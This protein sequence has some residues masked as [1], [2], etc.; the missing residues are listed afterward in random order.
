M[1]A[2][3]RLAPRDATPTAASTGLV[4]RGR[5]SYRTAMSIASTCP[6]WPW[7]PS[8]PSRWPWSGRRARRPL[9][10]AVR[11]DAAAAHAGHAGGDAARDR[12]GAAAPQP[13]R[14]PRCASCSPRRSRPSAMTAT[15]TPSPSAAACWPPRPRPWASWPRAS[16][17]PSPRR[18]RPCSPPK[19]RIV[20][21]RHR[22]VGPC[23]AQDR[24]HPRLHR[25]AGH[26]RPRH[27]GQPRRPRHDRRRTTWSWRSPSPA[28][29]ASWPT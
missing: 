13:S 22:Q 1:G 27:R 7:S 15:S 23:G 19:G 21:H 8:P 9:A 2:F 3:Y 18:S 11:L 6:S 17:R 25:L 28:R 24:R 20:L 14:A 26:V 16:T 5:S 29:P 10:R 4:R 12:R